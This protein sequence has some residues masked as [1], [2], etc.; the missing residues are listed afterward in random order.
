[1]KGGWSHGSGF[2]SG[3]GEGYSGLRRGPVQALEGKG[4]LLRYCQAN[5]MSGT[6]PQCKRISLN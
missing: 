6:E 2:T 4:D 1:L 5:S 3:F